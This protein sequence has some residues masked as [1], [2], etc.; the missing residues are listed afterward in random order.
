MQ[1]A[2]ILVSNIQEIELFLE[3][4]KNK[5]ATLDL[6]KVSEIDIAGVQL[7]LKGIPISNPSKSILQTFVKLNLEIPEQS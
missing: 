7:I 3:E 1:P 5:A 6:S 4:S 2:S